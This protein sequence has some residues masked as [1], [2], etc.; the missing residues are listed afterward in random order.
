MV[1]RRIIRAYLRQYALN[2]FVETGTFYGDTLAYV[3]SLG[4]RCH[5]TELSVELHEKARRRFK[6]QPAVSL[7]LGDSRCTLPLITEG[8]SEPAL[9]W[10]DAHFS[11]GKTAGADAPPPVVDELSHVLGRPRGGRDVVLI[12]DVRCFD[13]TS[14][15][16][17]LMDLL[18]TENDLSGRAFE[19]SNDIL[20]ITPHILGPGGDILT[21]FKSEAGRESSGA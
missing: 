11:G 5:S 6:G 18:R 15:F 13:G 3:A 12:D 8:L 19:I 17:T 21:S 10:L 2:I 16:P 1:K 14:G 4:V 20:R 9:F 7:Y